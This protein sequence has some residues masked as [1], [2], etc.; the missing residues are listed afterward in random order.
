MPG[1]Q[2][3]GHVAR[4]HSR[5]G[6]RPRLFRSL[7]E[8]ANDRQPADDVDRRGMQSTAS[9]DDSVRAGRLSGFAPTGHHAG[10]QV[11][12][13]WGRDFLGRPELSRLRRA[14]QPRFGATPAI[15]DLYLSSD[16][17]GMRR[18]P[19]APGA[20]ARL[21]QRCQVADRHFAEPPG[22]GAGGSGGGGR[23]EGRP[24]GARGNRDARKKGPPRSCPTPPAAVGNHPRSPHNPVAVGS[25]RSAVGPGTGDLAGRA[26]HLRES[27]RG[28]RCLGN[29][30]CG[31]AGRRLGRD[32]LLPLSDRRPGHYLARLPGDAA[33]PVVLSCQPGW[34]RWKGIFG[35]PPWSAACST[36][37]RPWC[38]AIRCSSTSS[39][40]ALP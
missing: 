5:L 10:R 19:A 12:E 29:R 16:Q 37:P 31:R 1:L 22:E 28:G 40:A 21:H 8:G 26:G 30:Q 13:L 38:S 32:P 15:L 7:G 14:R 33:E 11:L 27:A 36:W 6:F 24:G 2:G 20:G 3:A 34:L 17:G 18:R 4:G 25:R 35:W 9:G 23:R 39:T